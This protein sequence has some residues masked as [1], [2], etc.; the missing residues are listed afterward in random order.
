[1]R[2]RESCRELG[3]GELQGTKSWGE[4]GTMGRELKKEQ[5]IAEKSSGKLGRAEES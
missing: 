4:L 2:A 5:R 3:W 1:M